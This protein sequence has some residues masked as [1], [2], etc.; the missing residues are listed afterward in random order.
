MKTTL[1]ILSLLIGIC[2]SMHAEC[3]WRVDVGPA[4]ANIDM[5]ESGHTTRKLDLY[6]FKGDLS[7]RFYEGFC[8]KPSLL[9]ANGKANLNSGSLGFGF[10]IPLSA[11]LTLTPC[12]G[13]SITHF[14]SRIN[15]P[16]FGLFDLREKFLS[17]G[18][19]GSLDLT[20]TFADNWRLYAI[21]QY[22][23]SY[24]KT[25]IRPLAKSK[26]H[27]EGPAYSLAIERDLNQNFSINLGATY[28]LSLSKEKHGLRG[29]GV[30]LGLV[31]WY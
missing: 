30:K 31:Y 24:A 12:V 25:T 18:V 19:Y 9:I 8:I 17:K 7:Y 28:N 5:L 21:Y 14:K 23:W 2:G 11:R 3:K 4:Y 10:C 29:K 1:W 16:D 26:D 20:W 13:F 6:A 22:T 15:L 27:T